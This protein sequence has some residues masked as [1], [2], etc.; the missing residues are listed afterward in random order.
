MTLQA[1]L[2]YPKKLAGGIMLSGWI[3]RGKDLPV[4]ACC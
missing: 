3:L 4:S 1:V 2:R